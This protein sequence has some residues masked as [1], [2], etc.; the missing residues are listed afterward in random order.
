MSE[1]Q[2]GRIERSWLE[3]I[4]VMDPEWRKDEQIVLEFEFS[5]GRKFTG[6]YRE[7]GPY[8]DD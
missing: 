4:Q 6:R 7:R 2:T 1:P 8:A 3:I 5:N